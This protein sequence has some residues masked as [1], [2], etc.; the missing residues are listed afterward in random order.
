LGHGDRLADGGYGVF[1]PVVLAVAIVAGISDRR[2]QRV[3]MALDRRGLLAARVQRGAAMR[4]GLWMDRPRNTRT[5]GS[6]K[7][8]RRGG[9]LSIRAESDVLGFFWGWAG[10][11][12]VFGHANW[13]L[14]S[15][16][17]AVVLGVALFVRVYEEPTLRKMFGT[18]YEEYC[19]N[20]RAWVP[21]LRAWHQGS[22]ETR[23]TGTKIK[24]P[25]CGSFL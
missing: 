19:R 5:G 1:C 17:L 9:V 15:A 23:Y 4:V 10:L 8:T 2:G 14:I 18:E 12:V 25:Q 21:R 16:A 6:P 3:G 24:Q 11:W 22:L 13:A 7:E 20:V